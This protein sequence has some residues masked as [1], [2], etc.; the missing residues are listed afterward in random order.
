MRTL[1]S[2]NFYIDSS[3]EVTGFVG[4]NFFNLQVTF[5]SNAGSIDKINALLQ[6]RVEQAL[7]E[8]GGESLGFRYSKCAGVFNFHALNRS[9]C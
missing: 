3:S 8:G 4:L 1:G 9:V 6:N 2:S 7:E 5:I